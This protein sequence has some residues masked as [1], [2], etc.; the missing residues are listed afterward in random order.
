MKYGMAGNHKL[1]TLELL[2]VYVMSRK[3]VLALERCLIDLQ[4]WC[5]WG[6]RQARRV[7]SFF[8]LPL[9]GYM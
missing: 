1:V 9:R 5:Y 8:I 2:V 4:K 6:M 7:T 3:L